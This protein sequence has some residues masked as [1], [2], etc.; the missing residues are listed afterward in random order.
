MFRARGLMAEPLK[1]ARA[2][3]E[4]KRMVNQLLVIVTG[5]AFAAWGHLLVHDLLGAAGAWERVDERFPPSMQTSPSFAGGW[6]L[7]MGALLVL[8]PMLG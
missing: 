8:A 7:V 6:L 1:L 2:G 5:L 3:V 4:G